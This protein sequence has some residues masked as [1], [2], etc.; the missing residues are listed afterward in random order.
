M[1]YIQDKDF[2]TKGE[3]LSDRHVTMAQLLVKSKFPHLNG[4]RTTLEQKK[5]LDELSGSIGFQTI[6]TVASL[7]RFDAPMFSINS[8]NVVRQTGTKDCALYAIAYLM[9]L[10][11]GEEPATYTYKQEEMRDHLLAC[12]ERKEIT[13]F[14]S[15]NRKVKCTYR[16]DDLL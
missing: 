12:F 16:R 14:P 13:S 8:M 11:H 3:W 9:S 2:L 7:F 5:P 15:K 4:L 6:D 10:A 1:I